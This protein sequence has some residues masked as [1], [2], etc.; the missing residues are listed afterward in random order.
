MSAYPPPTQNVPIFDSNDFISI[1]DAENIATLSQSFLRFPVSQGSEAISGSLITTGQITAGNNLIVSGTYLTNYIEY[2]D[3]SRQYTATAGGADPLS[4]VLTA[5]NTAT[6]SIALNN[7]GTGTNVISLLPNASASNPTIVL[8]D[9]TTTNTIDKNGYTTR[10]TTANATHYL[11]FSD[12]STTGTGAI[13]KTA[14]ISCNPSTNTVTATTFSGALSGNASSATTA[15]NATNAVNCSTTSTTTA[16]TYYPVFVSSNVTGN[17]PNLVGVMTYNPSSNTITANTFN[18][19]LSG[20]ATT[21]TNIAGGLGGSIPYQTAVNTTAL[22]ANGTAGQFLQSNGT[23]LAPSWATPAPASIT[24]TNINTSNTYYPVFVTG[25]G[26]VTPY[27][28]TTTA[29]SVNPTT[30]VVVLNGG[31]LK[32]TSSQLAIGNGAGTTSQGTTSIAIGLNAGNSLQGANN[33]AIGNTAGQYSQGTGAV[34]IGNGAGTGTGTTIFQGANS[35]AIG[36]SAGSNG[37]TGYGGQQLNC[38]AIGNGA[39]QYSQGYTNSTNFGEAVAIGLNAGQ[40]TATAGTQQKYRAVAIGTNAGNSS[41]GQEA[42]ALGYN[43]GQTNQG[44]TSVAMGSYAGQI[45]QGIY[46]IA[47]GSFCA[48]YYQ[49]E[50]CVAIGLNAGKGAS[51]T[52]RQGDNAVAIG[53]YAGAS[54]TTSQGANSIAIGNGAGYNG[55]GTSAIAIGYSAGATNQGNNSICINSSG[56]S[57]NT[58]TANTLVLNAGTSA[59]TAPTVSGFYVNPIRSLATTTASFLNVIYNSTTSEV[60]YSSNPAPINFATLSTATSTLTAPLAS[61]YFIDASI[62]T[63]LVLPTPST[64]SGS[65]VTFR[66]KTTTATIPITVTGGSSIAPYNAVAGVV[67]LNWNTVNTT[68]ICDGT[69]WYQINVSG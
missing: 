17:Y 51:S 55:L 37:I 12:A 29:F 32:M 45:N 24:T 56:L 62:V 14:G 1:A 6:N 67:T 49:G 28:N 65:L 8:T 18:G 66:K 44:N 30:G 35:V 39:G 25:A 15:T 50:N 5:G 26:A 54:T 19:A 46:S 38:V 52:I 43:A 53:A 57:Q 63:S 22:L 34:A 47:L 68:F 13:Q 4:S 41:Q 59:I 23:T 69:V 21:A 20:T 60:V 48:S 58:T 11:N 64:C 40:G 36:T 9:G 61:Y 42:F 10:N 31:G 3:G 27:I 16:G 33:V 2:P 7:T